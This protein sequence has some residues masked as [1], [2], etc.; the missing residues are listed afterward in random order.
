MPGADAQ[1][2]E[3]D[4]L[5]VEGLNRLVDRRVVGGDRGG[6]NCEGGGAAALGHRGVGQRHAVDGDL[7]GGGEGARDPVHRDRGLTARQS[8]R[9]LPGGDR[10]RRALAVDVDAA[11][12]DVVGL[13]G[14]ADQPHPRRVLGVGADP[15]DPPRI[16]AADQPHV[17]LED[18]RVG[19]DRHPVAA[20]A[21][22]QQHVAA[23]YRRVVDR[24]VDRVGVVGRPVARCVGDERLAAGEVR[25]V[26]DPL[27][28]VDQTGRR[29]RGRRGVRPLL[30]D[31]GHQS[32][33]TTRPPTATVAGVWVVE[34]TVLVAVPQTQ[35]VAGRR[36]VTQRPAD[37]RRARRRAGVE[38]DRPRVGLRARRSARG[39]RHVRCRDRLAGIARIGGLD[40][41]RAGAGVGRHRRAQRQIGRRGDRHVGVAEGG[42]QDL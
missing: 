18:D 17:G 38:R 27:F 9:Q 12:G 36:C 34:I 1:I 13:L 39:R 21:G 4:P 14:R 30:G 28:E 26:G 7:P 32:S 29:D 41:G 23:V 20:R 24:R 10:H 8:R 16:A 2:L 40:D 15:L 42:V 5:A 22:R 6:G 19:V 11:Q 35:H 33:V 31:E 25:V 3:A 37:D